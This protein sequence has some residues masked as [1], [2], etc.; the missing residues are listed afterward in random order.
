MVTLLAMFLSSRQIGS[1]KKKIAI[2]DL[3][4]SI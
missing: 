4:A 3:S 2:V 1:S